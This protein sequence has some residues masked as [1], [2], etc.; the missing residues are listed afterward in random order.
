MII[1]SRNETNL[2]QVLPNVSKISGRNEDFKNVVLHVMPL[3]GPSKYT[4][5]SLLRSSVH[6]AS[7]A[8]E[9]Q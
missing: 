7:D 5:S 4:L 8:K 2:A 1:F 6:G 9:F 3:Y